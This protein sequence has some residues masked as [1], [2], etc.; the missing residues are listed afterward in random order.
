[1]SRPQPEE[2]GVFYQRYIDTVDDDVV[3]EL[4]IQISS[5]E[6]S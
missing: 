4:E 2:F 6:A 5:F 1:M 3:T